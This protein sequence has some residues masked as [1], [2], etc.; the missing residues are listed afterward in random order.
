MSQ[1]VGYDSNHSV[2]VVSRYWL[3]FV[4]LIPRLGRGSPGGGDSPS[5]LLALVDPPQLDIVRTPF[6]IDPHTG[7]AC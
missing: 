5:G 3:S 6:H 7:V 4:R 1:S 2:D